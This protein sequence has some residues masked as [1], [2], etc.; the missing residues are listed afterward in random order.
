VLNHLEDL[1]SDFRVYYRLTPEDILDLSGPQFLALAR[2]VPAYGGVMAV[3]IEQEE[4]G[5]TTTER[6]SG[7]EKVV[8]ATPEGL[9]VGG[10]SDLF[11][12]GA[13]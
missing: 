13:G 4:G 10:V 7:A 6:T 11:T 9:A 3:R 1:E 12:F 2:R 8:P 5:S